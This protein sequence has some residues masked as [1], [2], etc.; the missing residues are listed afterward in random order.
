MPEDYGYGDEEV[1]E[2]NE[3]AECVN[4]TMPDGSECTTE[5]AVEEA[6]DPTSPPSFEEDITDWVFPVESKWLDYS[7]L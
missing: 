4:G 2:G 7:L 3:T 6:G 1:A 5:E